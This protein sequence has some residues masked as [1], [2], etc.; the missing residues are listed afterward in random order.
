M[1]CFKNLV[2]ISTLCIVESTNTKQ[3]RLTTSA[4][5]KTFT[6]LINFVKTAPNV[7]ENSMLSEQF[8]DTL[9]NGARQAG[10]EKAQ[11]DILIDMASSR[12]PFSGN[13]QKDKVI[14]NNYAGQKEDIIQEYASLMGQ[15]MQEVSQMEG[16]NTIEFI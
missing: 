15:P 4:E 9:K 13:A 2:I 6:E 11:F 10:L 7:W 8:V 14:A 16:Q 3:M 12:A 1:N 5:P